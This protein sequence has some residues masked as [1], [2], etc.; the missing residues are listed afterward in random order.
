MANTYTQLYIHYIFAVQNRLCIINKKWQD[1]LYKYINGIVE[2]QGHKLFI[3]NGMPDHVHTLNQH[4][5]QTIA[6]R[7]IISFLK[8]NDV[9][10][11]EKYVFKPID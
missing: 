5:S 11:D 10:Y 1:D 9:E 3:I 4:E 8:E 6:I 2:L 7:F